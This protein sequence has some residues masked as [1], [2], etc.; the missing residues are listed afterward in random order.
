MHLAHR[1]VALI[2][3]LNLL[4]PLHIICFASPISSPFLVV[5]DIESPP[6]QA[7]PQSAS[8]ASITVSHGFGTDVNHLDKRRSKEPDFRAFEEPNSGTDGKW[9]N[10]VKPK[11]SKDTK[12][13][14]EANEKIGN[15]A[16]VRIMTQSKRELGSGSYGTVFEGTWE[17]YSPHEDPVPVAI[18]IS[19]EWTGYFGARVLAR[20]KSP[21]VVGIYQYALTEKGQSIAAYEKLGKSAREVWRMS[22]LT[23]GGG[24]YKAVMLGA[25]AGVEKDIFHMDIKPENILRSGDTWKLID[26]DIFIDLGDPDQ[27]KIFDYAAGTF[28]Y[29]APGKN[30]PLAF[31]GYPRFQHTYTAKIR[32][33]PSGFSTIPRG[34]GS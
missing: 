17:R 33:G 15:S 12:W 8:Y 5:R 2:V 10:R 18:K 23:K 1:L 13:L 34:V 26:W 28:F 22:T 7:P 32:N 11:K 19:D 9:L 4:A 24:F 6:I 3:G 25:L 21:Y 31:C 27:N 14:I 16:Q 29:M 30:N 20:V